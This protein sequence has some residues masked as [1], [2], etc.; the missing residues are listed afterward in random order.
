MTRRRYQRCRLRGFLNPQALLTDC[1]CSVPLGSPN[2]SHHR[3]ERLGVLVDECRKLLSQRFGLLQHGG[4]FTLHINIF[5]LCQSS[6]CRPSRPEQLPPLLQGLQRFH[7]REQGNWTQVRRG[8][9][10]LF[11]QSACILQLNDQLPTKESLRAYTRLLSSSDR[12]ARAG[13]A[14]VSES[15]NSTIS[16][17]GR[18]SFF[19]SFARKYLLAINRALI[20]VRPTISLPGN[21]GAKGEGLLLYFL[22]RCVRRRH[23]EIDEVDRDLGKCGTARGTRPSL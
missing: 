10:R 3:I 1:S 5:L 18:S 13:S 21:I 19:F 4:H 12:T 11:F 17:S 23:F 6:D 22:V 14:R 20:G 9:V 7:R 2:A 15:A 8:I 16:F